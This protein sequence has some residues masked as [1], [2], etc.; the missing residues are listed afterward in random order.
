MASCYR[1]SFGTG[2]SLNFY[3]TGG[4]LD[5]WWSLQKD[6]EVL[7]VPFEESMDYARTPTDAEKGC[8]RSSG[9]EPG[10]PDGNYGLVVS[11][12]VRTSDKPREFVQC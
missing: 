2:R 10:Y 12:E 5:Q 1:F 3:H 6:L 4:Q 8:L 7:S 9:R 11:L